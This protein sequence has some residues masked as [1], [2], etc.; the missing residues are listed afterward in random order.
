MDML[1][2]AVLVV[3]GEDHIIKAHLTRHF[4]R[5]LQTGKTFHCGI[6]FDEVITLQNGDT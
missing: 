2:L 4:E 5:R 6:A 3:L 1:Y